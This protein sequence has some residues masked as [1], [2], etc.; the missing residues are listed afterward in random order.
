MEEIH[1][2]SF[3]KFDQVFNRFEPDTRYFFRG[4]RKAEFKLIPSIGRIDTKNIGYFNENVIFKIFKNQALP[5]LPHRPINDREWLA[6][7]QH[8]GLPTRLLDWTSNPLI[9]LYFAS[10]TTLEDKDKGNFAVYMLTKKEGILYDLPD[11]SPFEINEVKLL[12]IPHVTKRI[13]NQFGYFTIQPDP[14]VS[15]D[16]L[17]NPNR[18][19][20]VIFPNKLKKDFRRKLNTY[21][22]NSSSIFPDV[23]GIAKHLQNTLIDEF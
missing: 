20:K 12:S 3:E 19:R 22:I 2:K 16:S 4:V 18:I 6:I 10:E 17:L 7:A 15:L 11:C 14:K 21:G 8:H 13:K 5:F 23:D 1:F 9:A